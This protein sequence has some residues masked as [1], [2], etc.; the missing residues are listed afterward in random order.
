MYR[1][2]KNEWLSNDYVLHNFESPDI[3]LVSNA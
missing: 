3:I 2:K 1:L